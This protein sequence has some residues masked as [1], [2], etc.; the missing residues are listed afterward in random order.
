MA[1]A[2]DMS[3]F[4]LALYTLG[5]MFG[6]ILIAFIVIQVMAS[7]K[8]KAPSTTRQAVTQGLTVGTVEQPNAIATLRAEQQLKDVKRE[9]AAQIEARTREQ[10]ALNNELIASIN[11]LNQQ[12]LRLSQE[13][14][15]KTTVEAPQQVV[16]VKPERKPLSDAATFSAPSNAEAIVGN[17]LWVRDGDLNS[18]ALPE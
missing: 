5:G 10:A 7:N 13:A 9:F 6:L 17:R 16:V 15:T 1:N 3:V 12:V 11:A 4:K 14:A 18:T 8:N 2:K